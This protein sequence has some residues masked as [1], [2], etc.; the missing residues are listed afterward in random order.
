MTHV[1]PSY[2]KDFHCI[3]SRCRH[4]CCIGWEIDIDG[5]S[6]EKY[7]AAGG[8]MGERL[9]SGIA[10]GDTPHFKCRENGRCVFLNGQNL[11]DI[12]TELGEEH[13]CTICAE[14]PRF[15][16]ELP[17]RYEHGL[18]LCCEEAARLILTREEPVSFTEADTDDEVLLLRDRVIGILQDRSADID[19]RC[20]AAL[21]ECGISLPRR[22]VTEW[23]E[24]YLTLERLDGCWGDVLAEIRDSA[25][26]PPIP[27]Y[28]WENLL[29][30]FVYR[31][32]ANAADTEDAAYRL[33]FAVLSYRMIRAALSVTDEDVLELC[34]L[35]SAEIEYS[36]DNTDA[37]LDE[38]YFSCEAL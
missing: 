2:Y 31:H 19:A 21:R 32:M 17:D 37:V 27:T 8:E 36:T 18:G 14:H 35:Y 7:M 34:R 22:S 30:Y 24:F 10:H 12:I 1:Y 28:M 11:C 26:A 6:Y 13:L 16:N 4:N 29:V 38:L 9:K 5:E 25:D 20:D 33:A 23:A 15:T 3:G